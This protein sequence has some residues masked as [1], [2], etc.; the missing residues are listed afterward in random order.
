MLIPVN[1]EGL[2]N[3]IVVALQATRTDSKYDK[4]RTQLAKLGSDLYYARVMMVENVSILQHVLLT[5]E[6]I[7][8][9]VEYIPIEGMEQKP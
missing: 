9:V 6:E 7:R 3:Q 8:L 1:P 2:R 4:V 5:P